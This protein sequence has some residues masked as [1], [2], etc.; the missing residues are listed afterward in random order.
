[1]DLNG[2]PHGV[3]LQ[4]PLGIGLPDH[5]RTSFARHTATLILHAADFVAVQDHGVKLGPPTGS[6]SRRCES[7]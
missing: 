6:G 4:E 2:Y 5:T 3:R 7:I 1:M